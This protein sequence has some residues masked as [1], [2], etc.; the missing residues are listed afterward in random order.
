VVNAVSG[1]FFSF[2]FF[3]DC[4][5]WNC[6]NVQ[7]NALPAFSERSCVYSKG[8]GHLQQVLQML[9]EVSPLDGGKLRA[10]RG[11]WMAPNMMRQALQGRGLGSFH[12]HGMRVRSSTRI[13]DKVHCEHA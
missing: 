9:G 10:R 1:W 8:W 12:C 6:W 7:Y 5:S 2:N 11:E 4:F 13:G 3:P